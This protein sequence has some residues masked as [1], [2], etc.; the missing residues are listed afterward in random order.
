[1]S[2][3]DLQ[4]KLKIIDIPEK[5]KEVLVKH[6]DTLKILGEHDLKVLL[7]KIIN[8]D[9]EGVSLA[10]QKDLYKSLTDDEYLEAKKDAGKLLHAFSEITRQRK[11]IAK[12]LLSVLTDALA[13]LLIISLF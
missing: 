10:L 9:T 3:F 12:E 2:D 11:E 1:M 13:K 6:I 5:V 7:E 4:E 8:N